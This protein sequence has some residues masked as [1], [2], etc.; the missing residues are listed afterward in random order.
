MVKHP[1]FLLSGCDVF[2]GTTS[3]VAVN[4][5]AKQRKDDSVEE[6]FM[7]NMEKVLQILYFSFML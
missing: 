2:S 7:I 3:L 6:T 5:A 4:A 1:D